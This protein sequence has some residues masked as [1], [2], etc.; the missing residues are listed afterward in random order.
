LRA[1]QTEK[2]TLNPAKE[3]TTHYMS[4]LYRCLARPRRGSRRSTTKIRRIGKSAN[5]AVTD[6][7]S[8]SDKQNQIRLQSTRRRRT[9]R[10][11]NGESTSW[12]HDGQ[13]PIAYIK[14]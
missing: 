8:K 10:A 6:P 5:L 11:G 14:R 2:A 12:A 4:E 7:E 9:V 3:M 13:S 1:K